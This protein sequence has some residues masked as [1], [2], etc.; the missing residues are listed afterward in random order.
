[1]APALVPL[2]DALVDYAGLFPPAQL[3]MDEAVQ[4]HAAYRLGPD[5]ARLGRFVVP[6][7]RLAEFEAAHAR[8]QPAA[9]TGWRL[10]A[11]AGPDAAADATR[12]H[13]YH[14]RQP[15]VRIVSV[16]AKAA[17]PADV[18]RLAAAFPASIEVW[19]ELP[20][21]SPELPALLDAVRAAGRGAKLRTG[22]TTAAAF[23]SADAV[24]RFILLCR[25]RG[26]VLKA[27]A[28]LH[29]PLRGDFPLTYA[30]DAPRGHMFGFLNVL[31]AC[32][33]ARAGGGRDEVVAL[34]EESDPA[35]FA[36]GPDAVAWR[37]RRFDADL[38][39][40]TRR[41]GFRSFGSCSFA[42]PL[43]GLRAL[44]WIR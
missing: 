9:R 33:L 11:L 27:T 41:D 12:L 23:P 35:A 22:G 16:E 19:L 17:Q 37:G 26:V 18:A 43:E 21:E 40:A 25:E 42:E 13:A 28:G 24:A 30:P 2:L 38:L 7:E 39:T 44:S 3:G 8:L 31:L 34:L 5:R 10:S 20:T 1:M 4:R 36:A 14:A 32:A 29:H 6:L 15:D